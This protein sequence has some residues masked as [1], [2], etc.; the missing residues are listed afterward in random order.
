MD[1]R[2]SLLVM[3]GAMLAL[4]VL[5]VF[6]VAVMRLQM[7]RDEVGLTFG[8]KVFGYPALVIGLVIDLFVHV[9]LGTIVFFEMPEAGEWTLSRR[10]WRLSNDPSEGWRYR[11]ALWLRRELLDSIDPRGYHKG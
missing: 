3:T 6:Y 11:L 5:W 7:V 4:W 2:T 10:L 8:Q 9:V 1:L